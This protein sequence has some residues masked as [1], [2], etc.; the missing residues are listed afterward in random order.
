MASVGLQP[1]YVR[2]MEDGRRKKEG[3]REMKEA[4]QRRKVECGMCNIN[5]RRSKSDGSDE[6]E[7]WCRR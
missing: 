7:W 5:F 3:G 1:E 4:G 2:K 6:G